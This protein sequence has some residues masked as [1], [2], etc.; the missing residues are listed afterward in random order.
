VFRANGVRPIVEV[1]EVAAADVDGIDAE[2]RLGTVMRSMSMSRS[3]V[4]LSLLVSNK[5]M[6]SR[7]PAGLSHGTGILGLKKPGGAALLPASC[8]NRG[9]IYSIS[10]VKNSLNQQISKLQ[11]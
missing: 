1:D 11:E 4:R 6:A 5:P 3:S 9:W 10:A 7:V 2:T 8:V